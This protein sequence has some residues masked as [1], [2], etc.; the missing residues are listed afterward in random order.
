MRS[1]YGGFITMMLFSAGLDHDHLLAG[2]H[3]GHV[4][5]ADLALLGVGVETSQC[6][7]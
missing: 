1:P 3:N 4:Q 6:T 2:G 7:G 5:I